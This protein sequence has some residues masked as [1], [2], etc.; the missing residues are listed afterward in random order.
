MTNEKLVQFIIYLQKN[1]LQLCLKLKNVDRRSVDLEW[2]KPKDILKPLFE[3]VMNENNQ[4][5][6]V[7]YR[8]VSLLAHK[9][10][11]VPM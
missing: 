4:N 8:Y 9:T 1:I 3:L 5:D 7:I 11:H 10:K 2:N 6:V